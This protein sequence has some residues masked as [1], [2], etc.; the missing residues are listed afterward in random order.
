MERERLA[1]SSKQE[2]SLRAESAEPMRGTQRAV[3]E[4]ETKR[5]QLLIQFR[6]RSLYYILGTVLGAADT[7]TMWPLPMKS[8]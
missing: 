4:R 2:K 6:F 1:G 5:S 7:K 3:Q 8:S